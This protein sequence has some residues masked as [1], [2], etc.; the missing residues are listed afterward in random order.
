MS[1][2]ITK[3]QFDALRPLN[4]DLVREERDGAYLYEVIFDGEGN[5]VAFASWRAGACEGYTLLAGG[6]EP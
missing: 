4:P 2:A 3:E 6:N 1:P 5:E